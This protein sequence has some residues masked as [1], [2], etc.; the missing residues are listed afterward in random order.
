MILIYKVLN[1][2]QIYIMPHRDS[3]Y[4]EIEKIMNFIYP[5]MFKPIE[6]TVAFYIRERN[7][8]NFCFEIDNKKYIHLGESLVSFEASDNI[9][10]YFSKERFID[11]EYPY[12][13]GKENI[14]FI[15]PGKSIPV[16]EYKNST[17]KDEYEYLH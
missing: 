1:E 2:A 5:Y 4:L 17:Q 8:K 6:N 10:E 3:L 14:F 12:A 15:F 16:E 13:Y 11:V 7:D 9:L